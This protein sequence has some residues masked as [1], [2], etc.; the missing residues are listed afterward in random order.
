[1]SQGALRFKALG[2]PFCLKAISFPILH[3]VSDGWLGKQKFVNE[4]LVMHIFSVLKLPETWT[5]VSHATL[6]PTVRT[7]HLNA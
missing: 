4:G 1:M 5:K 6:L 3:L 2:E 7:L